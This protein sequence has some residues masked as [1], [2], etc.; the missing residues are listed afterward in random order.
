MMDLLQH[1]MCVQVADRKC[2]INQFLLLV[3]NIAGET[4]HSI[5]FLVKLAG[6][7]WSTNDIPYVEQ[8]VSL[9]Y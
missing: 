3:I 2:W 5:F 9:L 7:V 6:L 4:P 1:F 8:K